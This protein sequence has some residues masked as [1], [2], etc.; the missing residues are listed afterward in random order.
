MVRRWSHIN[1]NNLD[2]KNFN[3][4]EKRNKIN[5]FK[6]SVNFKRFTFKITKFRRKSMARFK[7]TSNWLIYTNI[8]KFWSID[9]LFLRHF[10]KIQFFNGIFINNSFIYNFNFSKI[11]NDL[12]SYNFNFFFSIWTKKSYQYY[13]LNMFKY[14]KNNNITFTW[15]NETPFLNNSI[16][17]SY[18]QWDNNLYPIKLSKNDIDLKTFN[19]Q[20]LFNLYFNQIINCLIEVRKILILL[21]FFNLNFKNVK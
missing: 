6:L 19:N 11:R 9:Y 2:F 7:H 3:K 8:I 16:N 20:L 10:C 21:F 5:I 17:F 18:S 12:H 4:F 14:F 15:F 13:N 1:T